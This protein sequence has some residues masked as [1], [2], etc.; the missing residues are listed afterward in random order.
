[1]DGEGKFAPSLIEE[2][3]NFE[4]ALVTGQFLNSFIRHA[5]VVKIANLAQVVNVIAPLK[6]RGDE[7]LKQTT[8]HAFKLYSERKE[9]KALRLGISGDSFDADVGPV[10]CLDTSCIYS[11]DQGNLSLFMINLSP[12]DKVSVTANLFGLEVERVVG[13]ILHHKDLKAVNTF[14]KQDTVV[15]KD[16]ADISSTFDSLQGELPPASLVR[17]DVSIS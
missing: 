8:F 14:E 3:Y 17:L 16:F 12:T 11:E 4:D 10:P 1:M 6:T 2:E 15:S 13:Q 5:D 7:L 9:G